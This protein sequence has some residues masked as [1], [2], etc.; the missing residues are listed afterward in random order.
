[1]E[2]CGYIVRSISTQHVTSKK[3]Y[4]AQ[5]CLIILAPVLMAAV[6]YVTFGRILFHVVPEKARTTKLWVPARLIMPIYVSWNIGKCAQSCRSLSAR[7][8]LTGLVA[9]LLQLIGAV[10]ITSGTTSS[11]L[12][13]GKHIAL[14]G[15]AVQLICFGMF[16]VIAVRFNFISKRFEADLQ[17]RV[18][19]PS[20][21][22]YC[23]FD[24]LERE[25]KRNWPSLLRCVNFA[26]VMI[27]V[28]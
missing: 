13:R 10:M 7:P 8:R 4:V 23:T 22:K 28:S 17:A 9:L 11:K 15:V 12:T 27:L 16:S 26:S 3:L 1:V 5:F 20:N 2:S 18:S 25:L 24:G 14:I 19:G 21:G 6:L